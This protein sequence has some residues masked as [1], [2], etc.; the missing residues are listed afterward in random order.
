VKKY[1]VVMKYQDAPAAFVV[2]THADDIYAAMDNARTHMQSTIIETHY[3]EPYVLDVAHEHIT[4]VV[5]L[6][7]SKGE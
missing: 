3:Y 2:N 5:I 1:A 7:D 6:N 4:K